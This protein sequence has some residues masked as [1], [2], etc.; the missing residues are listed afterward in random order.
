MLVWGHRGAKGAHTANTIEAMHDAL[1]QGADGLEF[2]VRITHDNIPIVIHDNTLLVTR[3]INR[4]VNNLTLAELK[5]V[6][7][8]TPIPT[9]QE[10]LDEFWGK[11]YLNIELKSN[12]SGESVGQEFGQ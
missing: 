8:D 1:L 9:L 6:S 10:V 2:D 12:G 3:G 7:K 11:T 5:Q 4:N